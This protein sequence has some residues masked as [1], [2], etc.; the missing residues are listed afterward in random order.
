MNSESTLLNPRVADW[1]SRG[2]PLAPHSSA[3]MDP[4]QAELR[5][6]SESIRLL[7]AEGARTPAALASAE[8]MFDRLCGLSWPDPLGERYELCSLLAFQ[9][10]RCELSQGSEASAQ[11]WIRIAVGIARE[12]FA[13]RESLKA[14][15]FLPDKER[16]DEL[17]E[18]F[19][20]VAS[21]VFLA[22]AIVRRE[23][24]RDPYESL[25]AARA[26][27]EW[28]NRSPVS[29]LNDRER[30]F[31]SC[32]LALLCA[33][34][35]RMLR[36]LDGTRTWLGML[37]KLSKA[38]RY[39]KLFRA[40]VLSLRIADAHSRHRISESSSRASWLARYLSDA[41]LQREALI[42]ETTI[43]VTSWQKGKLTVARDQFRR[44]VEK[45]RY[46]SER[47]FLAAFLA[48]LGEID[49][50]E[51]FVD[52]GFRTAWEGVAAACESGCVLMMG[53][54]L[55]NLAEIQRIA[56]D[57]VAAA[58][59]S[60][61]SIEKLIA[62]RADSWVAYARIL[63]AEL[64]IELKLWEPARRELQRALVTA[65]RE[66]MREE[67]VHALKLLADVQTAVGIIIADH[68]KNAPGGSRT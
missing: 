22:Y 26:V 31:L 14:F 48:S 25:T 27:F 13:A 11:M 63:Y 19:L 41:G 23:A 56:G 17:F 8:E 30:H 58:A 39:H 59:T 16:S 3:G 34:T 57:L 62:A 47:P 66:Q 7:V 46:S 2:G 4:L 53:T 38:N 49:A 42:V 61:E 51:G 32:E 28:I 33:S 55:F 52:Q 35:N 43:A 45:W 24:D 18:S 40:K 54:T 21:D 37:D 9:A 67:G 5:G 20:G 36:S 10:W 44:L 64:L 1:I 15:M 50:R 65:S 60:R 12:E 6:I 68:S 29:D